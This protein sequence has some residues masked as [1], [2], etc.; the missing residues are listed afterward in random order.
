VSRFSR[1]F[2]PRYREIRTNVFAF[3]A[4]LNFE[5]TIQQRMVLQALQ[6]G[7]RRVAVKSG[8]GVGKTAFENV[9]GIWRALRAPNALTVVSAPTMKQLVDVWI[10]EARRLIEG[11]QPWLRRFIEVTKSRIVIGGR[12]DW[13]VKTITATKPENLAG[14]HQKNLTIILDEASGIPR[15]L[16]ETIEGALT[17]ED[18]VYLQAGNPTTRDCDF[19]DCFGKNRDRWTTFT[20]NS[21]DSPLVAKETVLYFLEKYGR[22]SDV[23]RI[24][25]LGEFPF[26]DPNCVMSSED[27]EACSRTDVYEA[28]ARSRAKQFGI[29]FARFGSD[30]SAVYRRSGLAVVEYAT[31]AKREPSDVVDLAFRMQAGASWSNRDCLFVPD[32]TGMGQGVLHKFYAR[33]PADQHARRVLEF[34]NGGT[35]SRLEFHDR[36][37][38]AW[39]Q[40]AQLAKARHAH[41]PNDS[42]LIQ[43]LSTRQYAVTRKGKLALESKDEFAKRGYPSPDRADALVMAFYEPSAAVAKV[44]RRGA[45][46]ARPGAILE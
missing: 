41:W 4:A 8:H 26:A 18:F 1:E 6:D 23:Y 44:L 15:S 7:A 12:T 42:L 20:F 43:Q 5:P 38:E 19:F 32:A 22:D 17:N 45:S 11:A 13:G 21:E 40:V 3:C 27:A 30:E 9:F 29:D 16:I 14:L 39:F 37:T 10:A 2:E 33:D 28:A 25:I 36:I 46:V 35:P 31:F 24:R 34:H